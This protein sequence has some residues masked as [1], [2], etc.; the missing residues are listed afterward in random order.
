MEQKWKRNGKEMNSQ[1]KHFN[2]FL[3][4]FRSTYKHTDAEKTPAVETIG[5]VGTC[6]ETFPVFIRFFQILYLY[7]QKHFPKDRETLNK[8]QK[9]LI[10]IFCV[11]NIYQT[12]TI[13]YVT[14]GVS[15][16]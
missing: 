3:S 14:H 9:I 10:C 2:S 5:T 4:S 8:T 16:Y 7:W 13:R 12:Y 15:L 1:R 11:P 6:D